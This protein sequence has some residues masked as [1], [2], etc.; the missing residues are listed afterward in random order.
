MTPNGTPDDEHKDESP[1]E[2]SSALH[3]PEPPPPPQWLNE[4]DDQA[5]QPEAAGEGDRDD[6][7]DNGTGEDRT[8]VFRRE[9]PGAERPTGQPQQPGTI[10]DL[11]MSDFSRASIPGPPGAGDREVEPAEG[12]G[13]DRTRAVGP[14]EGAAQP[15]AHLPP[16]P[17]PFPWA[18]QIPGAPPAAQ[19]PPPPPVGTP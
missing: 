9:A 4:V 6:R 3:L 13:Q 10:A 15:D 18:Q 12:E 17:P 5:G 1:E 14:P 11:T 8:Q 19:A 2:G 7:D 16:P